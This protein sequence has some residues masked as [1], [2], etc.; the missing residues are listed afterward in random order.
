MRDRADF[1]A[2]RLAALVI[3]W[4]LQCVLGHIAGPKRAGFLFRLFAGNTGPDPCDDLNGVILEGR[5]GMRGEVENVGMWNPEVGSAIDDGAGELLGRYADD[6]INVTLQTQSLANGL[7]I[8]LEASRPVLIGD[9]GHVII[10]VCQR[11]A[12]N[13]LDA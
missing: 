2:S 12:E 3:L 7:G 13:R 5:I 11:A 10:A 8:L 4:P 6:L 9:H 1:Q